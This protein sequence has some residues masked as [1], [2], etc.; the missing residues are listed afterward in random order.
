M[1][2]FNLS[3]P[4]DQGIIGTLD[5]AGVLTFVILAGEGSPIRGTE[6]FDLMMRAYGDKIRAVRGVWRQGFSGQASVNLDKVNELT[7]TGVP[8]EQA[9]AATW[10]AT[11]AKRWGYDRVHILAE[12]RGG[13][14]AYT[15]IDVL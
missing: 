15:K 2:D 5:D 1:A 7:A 10:T 8:L 6:L 13:P 11:R 3:L 4:A 12:P 14:G 9:I